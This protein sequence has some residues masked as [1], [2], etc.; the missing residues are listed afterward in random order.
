MRAWILILA[1]AAAGCFGKHAVSKPGSNAGSG[2]WNPFPG[3]PGAPST[4]AL[5]GH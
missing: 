3:T 2:D 4:P 1:I 5:T